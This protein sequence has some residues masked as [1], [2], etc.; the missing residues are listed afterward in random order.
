[1][2]QNTALQERKSSLSIGTT[3]DPFYFI[4]EPLDH[5]VAPGQAVS[6]GN[7]LRIIVEPIG[8]RDQFCNPT[9]PNSSFPLL[10]SRLPLAF[11]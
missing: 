7:S 2:E 4:D 6:I 3:L 11:S 10:Q 8:K 1:M 5:P 9:G